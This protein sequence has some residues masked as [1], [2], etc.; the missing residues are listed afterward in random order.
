[1][2]I[3]RMTLMS[4]SITGLPESIAGVWRSADEKPPY[5]L[6]HGDGSYAVDIDRPYC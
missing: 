1:V 3:F 6:R 2:E 5:P 4:A